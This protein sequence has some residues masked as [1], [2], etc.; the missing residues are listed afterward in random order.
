MWVEV[1]RASRVSQAFFVRFGLAAV[2]DGS[3]A[4]EG[5]GRWMGGGDRVWDG[6][7]GFFAV[8]TA[9]GVGH[10]EALVHEMLALALGRTAVRCRHLF[11]RLC[12]E[13]AAVLLE[14]DLVESGCA[15]VGDGGRA[16]YFASCNDG[17]WWKEKEKCKRNDGFHL[18]E[19]QRDS[20][21]A[22]TSRRK[23]NKE[24]LER[25]FLKSSKANNIFLDNR[26]GWNEEMK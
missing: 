16:I 18:E 1:G 17:I 9:A 24:F 26:M 5:T 13:M 15:T 22:H 2:V 4:G 23:K 3:R 19:Q 11:F 21:T 25:I 8:V 20:A 7:F 10:V 14:A 12:D 6:P